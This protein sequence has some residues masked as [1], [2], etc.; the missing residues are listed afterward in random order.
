MFTENEQLE[1]VNDALRAV[2]PTLDE[3]GLRASALVSNWNQSLLVRISTQDGQSR[4]YA[5][6]VDK[7]NERAAIQALSFHRND[8]PLIITPYVPSKVAR[9]W[10]EI[11]IDYVDEAGNLRLDWGDRLIDVEGR[12]RPTSQQRWNPDMR[13]GFT[14]AFKRGGVQVI[15]ALLAWPTLVEHP[16]RTI[17]KAAD[18]SLGTTQVVMSELEANGFVHA[19]GVRRL[20]RTSELLSRW[21]SAYATELSPKL[22]LGRFRDED[23]RWWRDDLS[24]LHDFGVLLGGESAA[25]ILDDFMLPAN[26]IL[27]SRSAPRQ[28]MATRRWRPSEENWNTEVRH[29]FWFEPRDALNIPVEPLVPHVLI[30]ADLLMSGEP[31]QIEHAARFRR[32]SN[33]LVPLDRS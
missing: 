9:A 21:S 5:V 18:V 20:A 26:A 14:R 24:Q 8:A 10:R 32:T 7:N 2:Q 11:G 28:L 23:A 27:Y 3:H 31:R 15:F 13:D 30:Y 29:K 22:T 12:K 4:Q 6:I 25:Y 1:I 19:D 33:R 16:L 17:S